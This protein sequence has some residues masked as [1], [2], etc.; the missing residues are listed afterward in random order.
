MQN[1][2]PSYCEN[3]NIVAESLEELDSVDLRAL[4]YEVTM[5]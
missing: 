4:Y 5:E 2:L 3:N 1:R